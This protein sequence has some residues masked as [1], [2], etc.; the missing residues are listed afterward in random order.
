MEIY[1]HNISGKYFIFIEQTIINFA[2]FVNPVAKI[3]ELGFF[4]FE[5]NSLDK[6]SEYFLQ[7]QLVTNEQIETYQKYLKYRSQDVAAREKAKLDSLYGEWT[8]IEIKNRI[9]RLMELIYEKI[10]ENK[11]S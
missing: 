8:P 4:D 7:H 6:S 10:K 9:N 1:K 11:W 3:L 2:N 5:E